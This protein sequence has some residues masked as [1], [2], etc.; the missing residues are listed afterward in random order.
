MVIFLPHPGAS[1]IKLLKWVK[2]D[3]PTYQNVLRQ[4]GPRESVW[5]VGVVGG[6]GKNLKQLPVNG[7]RRADAVSRQTVPD[8]GCS[9][10]ERPFA[11]AL[12]IDV[13]WRQRIKMTMIEVAMWNQDRRSV[14]GHVTD[15]SCL[16]R[17]DIR[18][19]RDDRLKA[20]SIHLLW[21]S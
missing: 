21:A 19:G 11:D 2:L 15:R 3:H 1:D 13:E 6:A 5:R 18:V 12:I 20:H 9:S 14:E 16:F 17:V 7:Q 8:N 4:L 10:I